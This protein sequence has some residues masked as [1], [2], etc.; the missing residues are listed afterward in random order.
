MKKSKFIKTLVAL[1]V[2]VVA[3][4]GCIGLVACGGGDPEVNSVSLDKTTLSLT[5][6]ANETLTATTD[7]ADATVTWSSSAEA[8]ATVDNTGKVT[9]VAVGTAVITA[10]A[11]D[12]SATCNVTVA[13]AQSGG[14]Q[15]GNQGGNENP[16]AAKLGGTFNW[17]ALKDAMAEDPN[18]A[19]AKPNF[20]TYPDKTPLKQEYFTGDNAFLTVV[21]NSSNV[22]RGPG[23][24]DDGV[25]VQNST[26]KAIEV[27]DGALSVT[28]TGAGTLTIGF[29]STGS[30]N[31]SGIALK[32]AEDT[33]LAAASTP[34]GATL[35]GEADT[36]NAG[37]YQMTGSAAITITYNITEA[38]TYTIWCGMY[39]EDTT[40]E[41]G[42]KNARGT[43]IHSIVMVDNGAQ[44]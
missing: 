38:G 39:Q 27:K 12:K 43:R 41:S 40:A 13:A 10:K 14:N 42:V 3:A 8:T 15:G 1:A 6:G 32:N 18:V 11:G 35:V 23:L 21:E 31:T 20:A 37:Y 7:P 22:L 26:L 25:T 24:K 34:Q 4:L 28:F 29:S 5:V 36:L 9:A 17:D 16:P 19:V 2:S 44:A 33:I 30:R